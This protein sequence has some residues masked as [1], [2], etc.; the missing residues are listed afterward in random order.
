VSINS[1]AVVRPMVITDSAERF[2]AHYVVA[3]IDAK[4][5]EGGRWEVYVRGGAQPTGLDAVEWATE[6]ASLGAGE[7]LL[8]SINRDGTRSGYDIELVRA[9]AMAARVPVVASGGAGSAGDVVDVLSHSPTDAALV[10]GILHDGATSFGE[11][12]RQ[13]TEAGIPVRRTGR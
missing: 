1:A 3:S 10:A 2:G 4:R 5:R 11:I 7:I 9:V 13:L 6:C 8:T 12:K